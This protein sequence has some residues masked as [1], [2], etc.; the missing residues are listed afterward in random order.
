MSYHTKMRGSTFPIDNLTKFDYLFCTFLLRYIYDFKPQIEAKQPKYLC[1][2]DFVG[3]GT[4]V[5]SC[6]LGAGAGAGGAD[7]SITWNK[8]SG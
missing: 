8:I 3:V 6:C 4:L 2:K 7:N 5:L 1:M